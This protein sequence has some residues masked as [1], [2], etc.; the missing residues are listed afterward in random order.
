MSEHAGHQHDHLDVHREESDVNIRA[1]FG[2]G[3][4]LMA[5][6]AVVGILV[7][8]LFGYF[9]RREALASGQ[10]TYPLAAS[11][12]ERLPPEPRLQTN[13]RQDLKDLL[14][15]EDDLLKG[16]RWVDRNAGIV[17][18]SIDEAMRLTL[19]RGLP[20]R[21]QTVEASK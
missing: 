18:I 6:A 17:R 19:Q 13:P 10:P 12:E 2:F 9:T 21:Q 8:L 15:A 3:A 1:I 14:A 7:W 5:F 20:S 4:G 11:Q 16:Y